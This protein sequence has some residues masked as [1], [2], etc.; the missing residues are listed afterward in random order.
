MRFLAF[1]RAKYF[2]VQNSRVLTQLIGHFCKP[3]VKNF[4]SWKMCY[5]IRIV[6]AVEY[7]FNCLMHLWFSNSCVDVLKGQETTLIPFR[8]EYK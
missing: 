2:F 3:F 4:R 1:F 5:I 7:S 8:T 6:R